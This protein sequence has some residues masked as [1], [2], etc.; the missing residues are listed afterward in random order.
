MLTLQ[1]PYLVF[2]YFEKEAYGGL[3]LW[4]V[5]HVVFFVIN[6]FWNIHHF[7]T[8]RRENG[9]FTS[10]VMSIVIYAVLIASTVLFVFVI[11]YGFNR[12]KNGYE[13][14]ERDILPEFDAGGLAAKRFPT[15]IFE[16][17]KNLPGVVCVVCLKNY[18]AKATMKVL[19]GCYHTLHGHC[20]ADWFKI[21]TCCPNC[22]CFVGEDEIHAFKRAG[23]TEDTVLGKIRDAKYL[24][25]EF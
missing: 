16:A 15:V 24:N 25:L 11:V 19:P 4:M 6:W 18:K 9:V 10:I 23:D 17:Y 1:I 7:F 21:N 14:E 3:F 12:W 8:I 20:A 22:K 5:A 2:L 13:I